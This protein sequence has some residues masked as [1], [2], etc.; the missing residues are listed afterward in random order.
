VANAVTSVS[1]ET[2]DSLAGR[3]SCLIGYPFVRG[4]TGDY[5]AQLQRVFRDGPA[6]GLVV[7]V[8]LLVCVAWSAGGASLGYTGFPISFEVINRG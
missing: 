8:V 5:V 3:Y 1:E 7:F 6:C 2:Q 4:T